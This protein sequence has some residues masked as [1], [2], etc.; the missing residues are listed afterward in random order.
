MN[1]EEKTDENTFIN[2]MF[3]FKTFLFSELL[4]KEKWNN[5]NN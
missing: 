5:K 3:N 1:D 2:N 4:H